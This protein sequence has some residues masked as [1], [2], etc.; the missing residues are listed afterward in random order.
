MDLQRVIRE[1]S[2][3]KEKLERVIAA[4]ESLATSG[5]DGQ[6]RA[7]LR[8]RKPMGAA[9]REQVSERMRRYWAARRTN[10]AGRR[11]DGVHLPG[12]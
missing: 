5:N 11:Q 4:L 3:E 12:R 8:G 1:L 10:Q 6:V 2:E 7:G 9:E